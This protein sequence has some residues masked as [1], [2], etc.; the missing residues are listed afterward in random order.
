MKVS[1]LILLT[2]LVFQACSQEQRAQHTEVKNEAQ[3]DLITH[4]E[5]EKLYWNE[6]LENLNLDS[7]KTIN[8]D[9]HVLEALPP[10]I[11]QMQ[12]LTNLTIGVFLDGKIIS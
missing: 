7:I 8:E 12:N 2:C 3:A 4:V 1:Y 6:K 10:A 11:F 5:A 9:I